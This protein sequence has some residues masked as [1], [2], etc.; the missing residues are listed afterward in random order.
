MRPAQR[1]DLFG[2]ACEIRVGGLQVERQ[3]AQLRMVRH[4][5]QGFEADLAF[6]DAGVAVLV[7][8]AGIHAVV[9]VDGMQT[10]EPDHTVELLQHAVEV[11][12]DVVARIPHVARV[13]AHAHVALQL[14]LRSSSN[15]PPISLP[16][17][18]IVSNSNVV[19]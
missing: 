10:V 7:R 2:V 18:A 13:Q 11:A 9:E 6:A 12:H 19:V 4:G 3:V 1:G 14:H 8:T 17:P 16:F 5:G 15:V